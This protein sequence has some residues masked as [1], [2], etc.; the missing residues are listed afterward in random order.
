MRVLVLGGTEFVGRAVVEEA[1]RLG[2]DVTVFNRG[3]HEPPEGVTALRGD[4]TAAGGLAA[5]EHG[6]WDVVVDTWSWAASAVR[7]TASLLAGR[8]AHYVYVSSRSVYTDPLPFGSDESAAVVDASADDDDGSN[9]ARNKAG[10]ELGAVAAF[11]DRAL[12]ARA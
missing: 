1:L 2:W 7:D 6:Q 12:L 10:A 8:A 11:G 4:R 3:S 5:L 9:Y